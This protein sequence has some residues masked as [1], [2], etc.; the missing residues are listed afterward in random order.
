M[1]NREAPNVNKKVGVRI[2]NW[3][4]SLIVL[5]TGKPKSQENSI[6]DIEIFELC[7]HQKAPYNEKTLRNEL[8]MNLLFLLLIDWTNPSPF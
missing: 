7:M 2:T 1:E 6:I 4:S 5:M 3:I 8:H